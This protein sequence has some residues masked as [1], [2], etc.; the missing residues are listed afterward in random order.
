MGY[1]PLPVPA[2]EFQASQTAQVLDL[3]LEQVDIA[4]A[5][6]AAADKSSLGSYCLHYTY[7]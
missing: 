3:A 5:V 2:E 7:A 1:T 4:A 6:V